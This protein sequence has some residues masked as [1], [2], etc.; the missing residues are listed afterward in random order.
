MDAVLDAC[1][2]FPAALRDTLLRGA[3]AGLYQP[4]WS[5]LILEE[6]RRNLVK[7]GRSTN[8][9]AERLI[10]MMRRAFP[11]AAV[12]GFEPLVDHMTNDVKDRHVV[13]AAVTAGAQVIVTRNLQDFP[14]AA[15][16]PF[17][18]EAQSP[19]E[20]LAYLVDLDPDRMVKI[21]IQQAGALRKPAK[22]VEQVLDDLARH[23]PSFPELIGEHLLRSGVLWPGTP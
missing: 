17:T 7:T 5:E 13:A 14:A 11:E 18:V 10:E 6:V 3:S 12:Q 1:I 15:L 2:L 22:T 21:V 19:D 9:Q 4:R 23:A 16:R 20:F 8:T